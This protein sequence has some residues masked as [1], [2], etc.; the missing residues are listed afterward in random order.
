MPY[1]MLSILFLYIM[2]TCICAMYFQGV[3]QNDDNDDVHHHMPQT[4]S[5]FD[6]M[7][8]RLR[9][10]GVPVWNLGPYPVEPIVSLG[11]LI[12]L[13]LLGFKGL[14]L[15]FLLFFVSK[16]SQSSA[17]GGQGQGFQGWRGRGL[18]AL[19]LGGGGHGANQGVGGGATGSAGSSGATGSRGST[20]SS[21]RGSSAGS[22]WSGGGGGQRLGR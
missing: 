12:A 19:G 9:T 8:E 4:G 17:Q 2:A 21:N 20:H 7:N 15:G 5:M 16:W 22:D 3:V 10:A 11:L 6:T 13:L 1:I 18:A 14:M